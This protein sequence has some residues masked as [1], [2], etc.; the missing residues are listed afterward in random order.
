MLWLYIATAI[1]GGAFVIPAILGGL[2]FDADVG[3]DVDLDFDA[4]DPGDLTDLGDADLDL[5]SGDGSELDSTSGAGG[6][7]GAFVGSLLSFR[8]IVLGL[9]FFGVSGTV[10]T[11]FDIGTVLTFVTAVVLGFVAAGLNA[12]LTSFVV[13]RQQSS[14]VTLRDM[15]GTAAEVLMP[16][17]DD[18]RG[19][20]R[21]RIA[22][23]TEYFTALP[24]RPGNSFETGETVVVVRIE[25][26]VARVASLRELT[27]S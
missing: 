6:A 15:S 21:A 26:G 14:H 23:Q 20:V 19:R 3:G 9:C 17:G 5:D 25:A 7:L 24:H 10:L 22:G 11:L 8:S 2:D 13:T 27:Q 4:G 16:I 12:A 18:R 1:F